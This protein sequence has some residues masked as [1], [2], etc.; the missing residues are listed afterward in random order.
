M[1][2]TPLSTTFAFEKMQNECLAHHYPLVIHKVMDA[3]VDRTQPL[4]SRLIDGLYSGLYMFSSRPAGIHSLPL[5][6]DSDT[7][8]VSANWEQE[9]SIIPRFRRITCVF[10]D[11]AEGERGRWL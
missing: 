7:T 9:R 5:Q 2:V 1:H 4:V 11:R 8:G 3:S 6:P 10:F